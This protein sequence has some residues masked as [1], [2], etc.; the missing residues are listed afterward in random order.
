MHERVKGINLLSKHKN[1]IMAL[2]LG[3]EE[4]AGIDGVLSTSLSFLTS[5]SPSLGFVEDNLA[6]S[7]RSVQ[8][9]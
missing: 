2:Y 1:K 4:G 3:A 8:T 9:N 5:S 6:A 7:G